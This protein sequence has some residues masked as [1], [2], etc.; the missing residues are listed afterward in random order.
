MRRSVA[1]ALVAGLGAGCEPG[2]FAAPAPPAGCAA[3][4]ALC[5]L[6]DGPIGVCQ[7]A[8]CAT[9]ATPPCFTCTPQH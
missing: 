6:P 5:Q 1:I 9:G 2:D 7:E 3:I 4:G 8:P